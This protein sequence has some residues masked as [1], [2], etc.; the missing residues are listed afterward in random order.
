MSIETHR[1]KWEIDKRLEAL[2]GENIRVRAHA[3]CPP[4]WDG[5]PTHVIEASALILP[6]NT[7]VD[8]DEI[9]FEGKLLGFRREIAVVFV[10]IGKPD[11]DSTANGRVAF[12]G[13][14]AVILPGPATV[15]LHQEHFIERIPT[16]SIFYWSH[17][18]ST[19]AQFNLP[20]DD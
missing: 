6:D 17:L 12:R 7:A 18:G 16:D 11:A 15:Q 10:S 13:R 2:L 3:F 14:G 1:P 20:L 5:E 8:R 4:N 9:Y 19:G